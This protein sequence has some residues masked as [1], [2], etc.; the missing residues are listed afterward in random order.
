MGIDFV[1]LSEAGPDER[2]YKAY[3]IPLEKGY[4]RLMSSH[5]DK[6][7]MVVA[8]NY[9][10]KVDKEGNITE[11]NR[12]TDKHQTVEEFEADLAR[13][14]KMLEESGLSISIEKL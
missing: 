5:L 14:R 4:I 3:S 9:Y 2:P 11:L 6:D 7:G 13:F 8:V 12:V 10:G 1:R